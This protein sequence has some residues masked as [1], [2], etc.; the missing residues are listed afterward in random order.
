MPSQRRA[1]QVAQSPFMKPLQ[2]DDA[3][4]RVIGPS[5]IPRTEVTKRIWDYI[6]EHNLQDP[7][8]KQMIRA[9]E[10]LRPV[11]GGKDRVTM[12]EIPRLVNNHLMSSLPGNA[13]TDY[14]K[15]KK[16]RPKVEV[17][18]EE[19]PKVEVEKKEDV[20]VEG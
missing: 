12:F 19:E 11:F 18:E 16:E 4:A 13:I 10:K 1:P 7:E 15:P 14:R 8:N 20:D 5:P 2:P 3:L 6:R 17:Q 9:D